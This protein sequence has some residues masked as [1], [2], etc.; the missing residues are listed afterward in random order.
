MKYFLPKIFLMESKNILN[1][2]VQTFF[3]ES[4]ILQKDQFNSLNKSTTRAR[5]FMTNTVALWQEMLQ[6]FHLKKSF[7]QPSLS[8]T[9]TYT[10][11]TF[12][13]QNRSKWKA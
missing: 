3:K 11:F 5:S 6:Y 13:I 10:A 4:L 1:N 2:N 8:T 9:F 12:S 7:I